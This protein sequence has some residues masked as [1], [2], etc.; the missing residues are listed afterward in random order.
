MVLVATVLI[1]LLS[2]KRLLTDNN[3]CCPVTRLLTNAATSHSDHQGLT[4]LGKYLPPGGF[5]VYQ[6]KQNNNY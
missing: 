4:I 1:N 5:S 2:S 6:K 3:N